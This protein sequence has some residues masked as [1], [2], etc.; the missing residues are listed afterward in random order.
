MK[1]LRSF[2]GPTSR[3]RRIATIIAVLGVAL[4]GTQLGR[5]WPREQS[6]TYELSAGA[7][8]LEVDYLQESEA[9]SSLRF[10][11]LN[12]E[13]LVITETVRLQPG[14]YRVQFTV[15]GYDESVMEDVRTLNVP[16]QGVVRFDL[17]RPSERPE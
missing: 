7:R 11:G 3:R 6:V 8:E 10:R 5:V 4:V 9:V 17:R 12:D 2:I 14:E 15:Y 16:A 13:S 1:D